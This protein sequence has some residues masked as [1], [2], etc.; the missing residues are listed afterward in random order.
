V[1][2]DGEISCEHL[3]ALTAPAY[4][5]GQV[6]AIHIEVNGTTLYHQGSANLIDELVPAGGVD[7]F[8]AGIAGR[9]FTEHY[10]PRI[11]RRLQPSVVVANHYDDFF[12]PLGGTLGFSTNV[13][14]TALP[15]EIATVSR[16]IEVAA[17]E[18]LGV[19]G[20]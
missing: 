7:I 11:L 5:C 12:R 13:N 16:S 1:P 6:Y 18:P 3:D 4:R 20:G 8:L 15:D 17:I 2:Y 14:L 10:W 9:S 19:R